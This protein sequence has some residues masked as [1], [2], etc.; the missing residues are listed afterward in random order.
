M[1]GDKITYEN[2]RLTVNGKAVEY[3]PME[4]YLEEDSLEL[5]QQ[6]SEALPNTKVRA[7]SA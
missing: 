2:K 7:S 5:R 1:P 3:A 4:D 6:Y